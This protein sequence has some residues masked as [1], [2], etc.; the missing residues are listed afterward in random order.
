MK[1]GD[2]DHA[3]VLLRFAMPMAAF[4]MESCYEQQVDTFGDYLAPDGH[5]G[6]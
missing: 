2:L 3:G 4:G 1:W 6:P 5:V